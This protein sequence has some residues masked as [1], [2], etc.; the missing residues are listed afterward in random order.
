MKKFKGNIN[1]NDKAESISDETGMQ[2]TQK[3]LL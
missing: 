2:S 3:Q 1:R